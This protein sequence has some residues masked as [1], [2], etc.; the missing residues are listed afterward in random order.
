MNKL[1]HLILHAAA[2]LMKYALRRKFTPDQAVE[3]SKMAREF[4]R[5]MDELITEVETPTDPEVLR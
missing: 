4:L 2:A 1:N 5:Q 3:I